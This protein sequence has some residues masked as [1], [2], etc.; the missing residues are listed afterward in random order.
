MKD[1]QHYL[2]R[3]SEVFKDYRFKQCDGSG[4]LAEVALCRDPKRRCG[5][6]HV[7]VTTGAR[8]LSLFKE[9]RGDYHLWKQ[10]WP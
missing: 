9:A 7:G 4:G 10:T 1:Q 2:A 8:Q 5:N 6:S 3:D